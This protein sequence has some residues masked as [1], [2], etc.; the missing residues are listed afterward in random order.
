MCRQFLPARAYATCAVTVVLTIGLSTAPGVA[1]PAATCKTSPAFPQ[2]PGPIS[3]ELDGVVVLSRCDAWAV[4]NSLGGDHLSLAEHWNG[5]TW[6]VKPVPFGGGVPHDNFLRAVAATSATNVWAV[7]YYDGGANV[8]DDR[9]LIVH[10][11]GKTWK[12]FAS[13]NPGGF[14]HFNGLFGVATISARSAWAVGSFDNGIARQ[15]LIE[16]WNGKSWKTVRS[17]D[18]GGPTRASMLF[19]V[20]A[21]SA[22]NAWAVGTYSDGTGMLTLIEHW[23]GRTWKRVK[24]P[25]PAGDFGNALNAVSAV[26]VTNAWAVGYGVNSFSRGDATL[27][28]HWNGR[29]WRTVKSPN[30]GGLLGNN[31][32]GVT[33]T[34]ARNAWAV[35][36]WDNGTA[37]H[38]LIIHWNGKTWRTQP[39]SNPGGDTNDNGLFAIDATAAT[40]R[41]T[42][43]SYSAGA[44][45]LTLALYCC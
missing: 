21:T 15:A 12:Q 18:P 31:L 37:N 17:P 35:G 11:N 3:N 14:S 33:A 24:S 23:N 44:G 43:G 20:T 8:G 30:P 2:N 40:N 34:S 13:R 1:A 36:T 28:E 19:G 42:V 25:S 45:P 16:H 22:S 29:A 4:G 39:S 6:K 10:W 27:I 26:S 7:G 9:T 32:Y 41:W 38:T 5:R